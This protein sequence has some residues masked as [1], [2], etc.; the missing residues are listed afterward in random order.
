MT[1]Y[2]ILDNSQHYEMHASG[3]VAWDAQS[4]FFSSI[5]NQGPVV[6]S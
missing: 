1:D 3:S 5:E 2:E 4:T 6:Q